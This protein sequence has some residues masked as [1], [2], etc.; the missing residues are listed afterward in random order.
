MWFGRTCTA[1]GC[2]SQSVKRFAFGSQPPIRCIDTMYWHCFGSYEGATGCIKSC[3][4]RIN[5]KGAIKLEKDAGQVQIAKDNQ[6][7]G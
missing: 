3:D 2:K 5:S 1:F 6:L 4:L 7:K